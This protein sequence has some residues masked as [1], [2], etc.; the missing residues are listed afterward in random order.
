MPA[1]R[2]GQTVGEWRQTLQLGVVDS[3]TRG[4]RRAA[5]RVRSPRSSPGTASS[6]TPATPPIYSVANGGHHDYAGNEVNRIGLLD[7]APKWTEPRAATPSA[8]T[9]ENTPT[10]LTAD[11]LRVTP[12]TAPHSTRAATAPWCWAARNG[13]TA[14]CCPTVDGFNL[15]S[16]DWDAAEQLPERTVGVHRRLWLG[17]GRDRATGDI[18]VFA[19]CAVGRWSSASNSWTRLFPTRVLGQ[20]AASAMDTKRNR[21]LVVGGQNNDRGLY[22]VAS[23]TMSSVTFTGPN[24]SAMTGERQRHGLRPGVGRLL[25]AQGRCRQHH[26]SH[27]RPD[28]LRRHAAQHATAHRSPAPSTACGTASCTC[29]NSRASSTS[30]PTTATPGSSEPLEADMGTSAY[31]RIWGC[32]GCKNLQHRPEL[33]GRCCSAR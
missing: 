28:L 26:L 29:L 14:G 33:A 19:N 11:P 32:I 31:G 23:N 8:Q 16:N 2:Q 17:R 6:S 12:T 18:Y 27:Q 13:A 21:I 5:T 22:D 30:P 25:A 10:T 20:Y 4:G 7:G 3:A 15:G 1:W 9:T 24:A